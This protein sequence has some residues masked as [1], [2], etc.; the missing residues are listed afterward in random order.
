M[1]TLKRKFWLTLKVFILLG[2]FSC[3]NAL[4][5]IKVRDLQGTELYLNSLRGKPVILYVWSRTCVGH[6]RHLKELQ[7]IAKERKDIYIVSYAV[8]MDIKDV[9]SSY[10]EMKIQ[11]P[12]FITLVDTPVKLNEFYTIEFLPSTFTFDKDGKLKSIKPGLSFK[13]D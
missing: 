7:R 13:I 9:K 6:E 1:Q 10:E 12:E 8:A 4:P 5:R 2:I 11:N 3:Q